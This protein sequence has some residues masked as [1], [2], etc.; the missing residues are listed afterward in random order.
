MAKG[1]CGQTLTQIVDL[2]FSPKIGD[3]IQGGK[4]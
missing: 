1:L 4:Q 2:R 3:R